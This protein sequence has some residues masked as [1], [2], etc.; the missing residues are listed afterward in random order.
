MDSTGKLD[1]SFNPPAGPRNHVNTT[2]VLDNG[3]IIVCG[4]F[5]SYNDTIL[6][7][8][9][10]VKSDGSLDITFDYN[11]EINADGSQLLKFKT[12]AKSLLEEILLSVDG[13]SRNH[14]ARL[15]TNGALDLSFD[16]GTGLSGVGPSVIDIGIQSDGKIILIGD[17]FDN[18]N[19][20]NCQNIF[21]IN[22][23]GSFDNS[24]NIG[25]G[26]DQNSI[27]TMAIDSQDRILLGGG[28]NSFNNYSSMG[29]VRLNP[30][31]SIDSSFNIGSGFSS[32]NPFGTNISAIS[33]QSNGKI[34]V[35]GNFESFNGDTSIHLIRLL[36]NGKIDKSFSS[37]TG[38]I[39]SS[40][41]AGS[42]L[43]QPNDK[44]I[45]GGQSGFGY[46]NGTRTSNVIRL[47][48][49]GDLDQDFSYDS[50]NYFWSIRDLAISSAEK[51][52]IG[53]YY[54][55][56]GGIAR[57]GIARLQNCESKYSRI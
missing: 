43:V 32:G 37:G 53:M 50:L 5:W 33:V 3:K 2:E 38:V 45:L 35:G 27:Y 21:R 39:P 30:D 44:I 8:I 1:K 20:T 55:Y 9:A 25:L 31:G 13:V 51:I 47:N 19:S 52:L 48:P 6:S 12:M 18:Y 15:D 56:S 42:I 24:F 17:Y 57:Y 26:L 11:L 41:Y 7:H 54:G 29:L 23:D 14:L 49:N 10:R 36:P 4:N 16:V 34:I 40:G 28:F 46:Y 22:Q